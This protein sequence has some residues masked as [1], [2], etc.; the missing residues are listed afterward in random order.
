MLKPISNTNVCMRACVRACVRA[1]IHES[2]KVLQIY[3]SETK[4][5][6]KKCFI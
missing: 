3:I 6:R 5:F 4:Y 2:V 1:C